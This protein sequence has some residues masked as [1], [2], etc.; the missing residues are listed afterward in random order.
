MPYEVT[1]IDGNTWMIQDDFVR[2]FLLQ[3]TQRSMLIDTGTGSGDLGAL[4]RQYTGLPVLL[5][6]THADPD[7]IGCN[8]AF[9]E[10]YMHPA[11]FAYYR[12]TA[13]PGDADPR[14][15]WDGQ[16]VDLGGRQIQV[17]L[18]PGHT[19]GSIVLVDLTCRYLF[20]GDNLTTGSVFLFGEMRDLRAYR[21]SMERLWEMRHSF[22]TVFP[23]HG[24]VDIQKEQILKQLT[25]AQAVLEGKVEGEKP[26]IDIPALQYSFAGASVYYQYGSGAEETIR[27]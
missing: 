24:A 12:A 23:S 3:G 14:P 8:R 25:C 2:A 4:V 7:H 13:K 10:A 18:L 17:L 9:E 16:I 21:C 19:Q 20:S 26:P 27:A 22:D 1:Q 11:E 5:V 15:L 6:N